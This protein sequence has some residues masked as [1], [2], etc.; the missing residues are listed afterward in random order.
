MPKFLTWFDPWRDIIF[1]LRNNA[2][3]F[4][5]YKRN[6]IRITLHKFTA[7]IMNISRIITYR[8]YGYCKYPTDR[9][10]NR[11]I[12]FLMCPPTLYTLINCSGLDF[13]QRDLVTWYM[14]AGWPHANDFQFSCF[15]GNSKHTLPINIP[16]TSSRWLFPGVLELAYQMHQADKQTSKTTFGFDLISAIDIKFNKI[17]QI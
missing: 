7:G 9:K 2:R 15:S 13:G 11:F 17:K 5:T 10:W 14:K 1:T 4:K 6:Y 8:V 12:I 3:Y 16:Q